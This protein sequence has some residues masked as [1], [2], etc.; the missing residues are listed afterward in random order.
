MT[1]IVFSDK[2]LLE[3]IRAKSPAGAGVLYDQ[4]AK[5]LCLA[6]FRIVHERNL[7]YTLLEQIFIK[8]GMERGNT[9]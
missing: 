6:I 5:V 2:A 3:S 9:V 8:Y 1:Q 7:T 4:Y